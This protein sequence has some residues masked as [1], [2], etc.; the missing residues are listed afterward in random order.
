MHQGPYNV[1][2]LCVTPEQHTGV[3]G[4]SLG[5]MPVSAVQPAETAGLS[6]IRFKPH[7]AASF[8]ADTVMI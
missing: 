8:G 4:E 3:A 2:I 7:S 5:M 1:F 6:C